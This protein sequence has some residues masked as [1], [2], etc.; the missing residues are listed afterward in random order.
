M[1][2]PYGRQSLPSSKILEHQ[3]FTEEGLILWVAVLPRY[4]VLRDASFAATAVGV[5][6]TVGAAPALK[7]RGDTI[8]GKN[9]KFWGH[10]TTDWVSAS[11]NCIVINSDHFCSR[12]RKSKQKSPANMH[13][14]VSLVRVTY[15]ERASASVYQ[16]LRRTSCSD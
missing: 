9:I 5:V 11:N 7:V 16:E 6:T 4:V 15:L 2:V 3:V 14:H 10:I 13:G 12:E 1:P 8:T